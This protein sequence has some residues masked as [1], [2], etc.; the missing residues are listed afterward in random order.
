MTIRGHDT[1]LPADE[2]NPEELSEGQRAKRKWRRSVI[3]ETMETKGSEGSL[4]GKNALVTGAGS[5]IGR[6]VAIALAAEGARLVLAGRRVSELRQTGTE[7]E[8]RGGSYL[9]VETD[10]TDEESVRALLIQALAGHDRLD[11][12]F[13][14]AGVFRGGA[15][16][17]TELDSF[18][19]MLWTNTVGTWLCLKHEIRTMK[20]RGG[21]VIVNVASN[22]GY[23]LTRP[24]TGAYAA[25]KAAVT[26]LTR[27]AA[28]EAIADGIR[29]NSISPGPVDTSM[30]YRSGEDRA[31]RDAR[32][33]STN[34][35]KRVAKLDEI[36]SAV[37]WLCSDGAAY[38]VGQDLVIDGGASV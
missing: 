26:V 4:V 32:I 37:L 20:P 8:G 35:S 24:G 18:N 36:A 29:I 2:A 7:I 28:L 3:L 25:S 21:G 31:A 22:I 6:Q 17:E 27:T 13:N 34:P 16:D 38:M 5:G 11:I 15:I 14:G 19:Q 12:A 9:A 10:I 30:S 33:A 1:Y 23:H